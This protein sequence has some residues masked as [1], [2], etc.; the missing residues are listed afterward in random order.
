MITP[1]LTNAIKKSIEPV[2]Q[3][4]DTLMKQRPKICLEELSESESSLCGFDV[5]TD[6]Q[7]AGSQYQLDR[8]SSPGGEWKTRPLCLLAGIST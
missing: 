5:L 3:I 1:P 6:R 8:R 7:A 4:N 2:S